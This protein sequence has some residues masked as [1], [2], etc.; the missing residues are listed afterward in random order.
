MPLRVVLR[1]MGISLPNSK[2]FKTFLWLFIIDALIVIF[3]TIAFKYVEGVAWVESI[4]QTWQTMTTVGFGN[5][6]AE[7]DIGRWIT[8]VSMLP[9]IML[10]PTL[11][12]VAVD[13]VVETRNLRRT[14]Q[15]K[16]TQKGGIV[17]FNYPGPSVLG[18]MAREFRSG[19]GDDHIGICIVDTDLERL[20]DSVVA[21]GN[22]EFVRGSYLRQETLDQANVKEAR[23]IVIFPQDPYS[24]D[25][26]SATF[27][28]AK[29][30]ERSVDESTEIIAFIVDNNNRWMFEKETR[31]VT[32]Y[33]RLEIAF[34]VQES[35]D[36]FTATYLQ[37]M[38][39]NTE[40]ANI[41]SFPAGRMVGW[42]WDDFKSFSSQAAMNLKVR[43]QPLGFGWYE[44]SE[45]GHKRQKANTCLG[46]EELVKEGYNILV[47]AFNDLNWNQFER[48]LVRCR[49]EAHKEYLREHA[50]N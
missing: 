42:S 21:L 32:I 18:D 29:L 17:A 40:G 20:P 30:L 49:E 34:A 9:A 26:D 4:W 35:H 1:S 46:G 10:M 27:T 19:A 28:A 22:F 24:V 15:M 50:Q 14:G 12:A 23:T 11:F 48:E 45:G 31:A 37:R 41:R 38:I 8:M 33:S 7:T 13:Y 44:Y 3:F 2:K 16:N 47:T 6:P 5:R 43:V 25:S 39:S 36:E